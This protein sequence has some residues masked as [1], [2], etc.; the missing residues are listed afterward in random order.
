MRPLFE[1]IDYQSTPLGDVILRRRTMMTLD[2]LEVY[3]I[4]LGEDFLMSSLFTVVEEELSR[5]GLAAT[6]KVFPDTKLDVVVG[7]LGLGYTAKVALDH[8]S[9]GS[10]NVVDYLQPVIDWHQRGLV[11]LGPELTADPRCRFV[12]GDFFKCALS[13]GPGFDPDDAGMKFHAVLLDIDHSPDHLLNE[14]HGNFYQAEGLKQL[15]GRL[16]DGGV[17]GL[18]SD[19]PPEEKFMAA[20]NEVFASVETYV[21]PFKN[22]ILGRDSESTVYVA[23][24]A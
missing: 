11:P 21:V 12:H 1:E 5:L 3:E 13:D 18:W 8:A 10:L 2:N 17:F 20:L 16:H 4:M 19:D 22:P 23:R 15:A 24:R 9:V 6:Q 14:A 7:G